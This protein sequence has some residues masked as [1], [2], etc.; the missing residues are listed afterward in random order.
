[1]FFSPVRARCEIFVSF[2]P[3][4]I[5]LERATGEG[6]RVLKRFLQYAETGVLQQ[7]RKTDADFD[8]P[9]GAAV[10]EATESLGYASVPQV[11]LAGFKIDL[12]VRDPAHPSR[13]ILAI[14][15]DG[16]TY[17]SALW[18]RERDRLRQQVLENLGWRFHRIWSTDWFYRRGEQLEKLKQVLDAARAD[19]ARDLSEAPLPLCLADTLS[20]HP[21]HS[22]AGVRQMRYELAS[23]EVP[24]SRHKRD[25]DGKAWPYCPFRDRTGRA[26][27]SRRDCPPD[28]SSLW[29]AT[30]KPAHRS[31]HKGR[32]NS[33]RRSGAGSLSRGGLLV[34]ARA[35]KRAVVRDRSA[36]PASLRKL[37]R[38]ATSEI[39]AAMAIAR[40]QNGRLRDDEL[41]HTVAG[42]LGLPKTT[43]EV[44]MLVRSLAA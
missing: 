25:R 19:G 41:A 35:E 20:E 28:R 18:A 44:R 1:M 8:S 5:N 38:I 37:D 16:A 24:R 31:S 7:S 12:A 11:G 3:G 39:K 32:F 36:A 40:Q 13:Y 29:Q 10:A 14:E 23:C 15:C 34:H 26:H 6:P 22:A 33:V 4:D 9:F 2:G 43:A 42:L 27:P 17:N 30:G 21:Q